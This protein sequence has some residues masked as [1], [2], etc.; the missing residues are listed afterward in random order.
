MLFM[1]EEW[2]AST[3]W[4]YFTDQTDPRIAEAVRRGRREEFA[5]HGWNRA[6]VPDPQSEE[7]AIR[8]R[9]DW[10][11][12]HRGLHERLLGW[13]RSLIAVRRDRP[14]LGDPRLDLVEVEHDPDAGTVVV[15]RGAHR[16]VVNLSGERR[17]V[18]LTTECDSVVV[19]AWDEDETSLADVAGHGEQGRPDGFA[20]R[21]YRLSL[22]A[23][24][25]AIVGPPD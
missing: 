13:Y 3:P 18:D 17:T 22:P 4:Q 10:S 24:A 12:V 6:D 2:G 21:S 16:V 1:G 7:T 25:A 23:H 14:D 19:V 15:H 11:E 8:S 5:A 20:R 9:L